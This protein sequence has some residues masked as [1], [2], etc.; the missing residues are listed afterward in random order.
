MK[1]KLETLWWSLLFLVAVGFTFNDEAEIVPRTLHGLLAPF[2][3]LHWLYQAAS[4]DLGAVA[5]YCAWM[6]LF[7]VG[8]WLLPKPR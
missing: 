1:Q 2:E 5:G 4:G 7:V 6:G 3:A 8:V